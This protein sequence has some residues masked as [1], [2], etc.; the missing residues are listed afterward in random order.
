MTS[1]G[2]IGGFDD[3]GGAC[4]KTNKAT[5][6]SEV[7]RIKRITAVFIGQFIMKRVTKFWLSETNRMM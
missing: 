4:A 7:V 2:A 6:T 5:Q 3:G 1:R